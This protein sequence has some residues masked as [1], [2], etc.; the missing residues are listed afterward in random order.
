MVNYYG[1]YGLDLDIKTDA[2]PETNKEILV[3]NTN[4]SQSNNVSSENE[5]SAELADEKLVFSAGHNA[6]L[7]VAVE[8]YVSVEPNFGEAVVFSMTKEFNSVALD[9]YTYVWGD[10]FEG[11]SLNSSNWS[12]STIM[13]S[14]DKMRV[15]NSKD[16]ID[17]SGGQL[18]LNS[19][20]ANN[21]FSP[22]VDYYVPAAV[23]T[24]NSMNFTYGYVEIKAKL[25]T[26][27]GAWPSFWAISTDKLKGYND[28]SFTAE[29]DIF[30]VFGSQNVQPGII[31]WYSDGSHSYWQDYK[32]VN[33]WTL[34]SQDEWHIY[35]FEWTPTEISMY[36]DGVKYMTFDISRTFDR[37]YG[38]SG[39]H[40]TMYLIF[41]NHLI[42]EDGWQ[43]GPTIEGN[44][45]NLP[46][47]YCI[48]Y[49]RVY[50]KDG[51]G[52]LYT[53]N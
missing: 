50:Q 41:N 47:S 19:V 34:D 17:V 18:K 33:Y 38:M 27:E 26:F 43:Q 25:P 28:A 52:E 1:G 23:T 21:P 6:L 51:V 48:D 5:L 36:V 45:E 10:E 46:G 12:F 9:G 11:A 37:K 20:K 24:E 4:R 44:E 30:E 7:R 31:K 53:A 49:I 29:I 40:D 22:S 42:T 35:G 15:S 32:D 2:S 13:G 14:T 8:M 3:G 16:V 39:F